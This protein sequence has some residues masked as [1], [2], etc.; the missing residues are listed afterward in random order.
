MGIIILWLK[1]SLSLLIIRIECG[2]LGDK[3]Q[4]E[5]LVR[6]PGAKDKRKRR[7][8]IARKSSSSLR[9]FFMNDC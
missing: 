2:L 6:P 3:S 9:R 8:E 5:H 1:L 7:G 4:G